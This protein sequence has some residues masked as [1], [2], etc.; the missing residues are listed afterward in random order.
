MTFILPREEPGEVGVYT[1]NKA[2]LGG[3]NEGPKINHGSLGDLC[4][5]CWD[6][7][8]VCK[9]RGWTIRLHK[10]KFHATPEQMAQGLSSPDLNEGNDIADH[11]A[12]KGAAI[13][14]ISEQDPKCCPGLM[15]WHGLFKTD[16]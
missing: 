9:D 7:Y 10:L 1:D 11:W 8:Q 16:C 4:G 12:G 14:G 2:I 5:I 3:W 13:H 6:L 15:V